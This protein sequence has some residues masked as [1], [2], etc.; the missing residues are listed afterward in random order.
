MLKCLGCLLVGP[1]PLGF[2][3]E[4]LYS[5]FWVKVYCIHYIIHLFA[6]KSQNTLARNI[7][8]P[9]NLRSHFPL[10]LIKLKLLSCFQGLVLPHCSLPKPSPAISVPYPHDMMLPTSMPLFM[11]VLIWG[12]IPIPNWPRKM[13]LGKSLQLSRPVSLLTIKRLHKS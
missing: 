7:S 6:V 3:A 13:T 2:V 8:L 10:S 4:W 9:R 12:S 5:Y 1:S 11:L